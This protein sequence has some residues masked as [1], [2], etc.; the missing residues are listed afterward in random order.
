MLNFQNL[1]ENTVATGPTSKYS[2]GLENLPK[3]SRS[4]MRRTFVYKPVVDKPE[5]KE[6]VADKPEVF[7]VMGKAHLWDEERQCFGS[8]KL[9]KFRKFPSDLYA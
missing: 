9:K 2:L 6:A 7:P 3:S 4:G 1:N 8:T 5:V